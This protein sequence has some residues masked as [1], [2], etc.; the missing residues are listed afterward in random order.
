MRKEHSGATEH[1]DNWLGIIVDMN[2]KSSF[3]FPLGV[4]PLNVLF[5]FRGRSL[6]FCSDRV[7]VSELFSDMLLQEVVF[8]Q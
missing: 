6:S 5:F 3:L 8:W 2:K 1:C 7:P 4:H